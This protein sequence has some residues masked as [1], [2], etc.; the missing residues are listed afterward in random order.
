MS[1][2]GPV[3]LEVVFGPSRSPAYPQ[4]IAYARAHAQVSELAGGSVRA[5]FRLDGDERVFGEAE[6]LLRMVGGWKTTSTAVSGSPESYWNVVLMLSCAR[7]WLRTAGRCLDRFIPPGG[8]PKCH[9]C[10][11]YDPAWASEAAG[12]PTGGL[13]FLGGDDQAIWL[14]VPDYPPEDWEP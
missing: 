9:S 5:T 6:Q 7:E 10:P 12:R 2:R 8:A 1:T 11:L 13:V 4:A 14:D 3:E